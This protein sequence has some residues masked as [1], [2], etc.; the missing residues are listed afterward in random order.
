MNIVQLIY[1]IEIVSSDF[2]ISLAAEKVHVSQSTMSKSVLNF[3]ETEQVKLFARHGKRLIGL[4]NEGKRFY[5]DAKK[6]VRDYNHM[7]TNV[8]QRQQFSGKIR[9]GIASAVL[10]SHFAQILPEFI[11]EHPDIRIEIDDDGGESLQQKLL[12]EKVDLAY[13]VAP[14]KYDSLEKKSLIRDSGALVFNPKLIKVTPDITIAALSRLPLILLNRSFT[15]REQLYT[16]FGY[17][18]E[19]PN[20]V[21]SSSSES[22]L[23]N[24]CRT[25]PLVTVL[26]RNILK[27]YQINDL[28]VVPFP[29]LSWELLSAVSK[30]NTDPLV[31]Q[32]R[33]IFDQAVSS[34]A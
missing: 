25:Q 34:Q 17:E 2:N 8:H 24:A 14:L 27:G 22:F 29:Q 30:K 1:F 5:R 3:E 12:L 20:I 16:L 23:L 6:V 11:L 31:A 19:A 32:V 9:L 21:M 33:R 28:S 18:K 26:P 15:I 13:V 4:T 7:I 10:V